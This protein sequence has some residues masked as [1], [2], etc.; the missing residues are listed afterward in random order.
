MPN[1][2]SIPFKQ[3]WTIAIKDA[4]WNFLEANGDAHPRE[5]RWDINRWEQLRA[6][7]VGQAVHVDRINDNIRF[8]QCI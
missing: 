4:T 5:F 2:L 3:T 1:Q 8:V 7:A 6:N